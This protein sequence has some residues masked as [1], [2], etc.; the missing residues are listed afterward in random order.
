[1]KLFAVRPDRLWVSPEL[2]RSRRD[3]GFEERLRASI[4]AIGLVEPLKVASTGEGR[5]LVVDGVLR[6]RAIQAIRSTDADRFKKI[7]VYVVSHHRRFEIRFQTDI[8]QDLLPSQLAGLVEHLHQNDH[9]RKT[10]IASYIGV[11]APTLRNY[12]GLWRLIQ[13]GGLFAG[14]VDLMDA[15]VVPASNPYA[16]LR[17]T[18]GGLRAAIEMHLAGGETAEAWLSDSLQRAASGHMQ[19]LSLQAVE[20][21]TG[22]L[23]P[24]CYREGEDVRSQKRSLGLRRGKQSLDEETRD[25]DSALR[26]VRSVAQ[27]SADAVLR[28]AAQSLEGSLR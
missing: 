24:D 9:V 13:R 11:S 22:G 3:K 1:M 27:H 18:E 5:Y 15:G 12:T 4:E 17:L 10:Q 7:P 14:V 26:N 21:V 16:W 8:Y 6:W 23:P 25:F 19:R 2:D 20:T 28:V